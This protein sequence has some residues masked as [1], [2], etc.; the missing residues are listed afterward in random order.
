MLVF[1][2]IDSGGTEQRQIIIDEEVFHGIANGE[3]ETFCTLYQ[4]TRS[5]VFTYALS[6]LHNQSDAE[7]AM[8]DTYLKIRASAHLYRPEGKPMAWILTITRN[9]CL[10]KMRSHKHIAD[11]PVED[12]PP[13]LDFQ[14]IEDAEDRIVLKT[15]FRV[16][17]GEECQI[18]FLH[19]V[20]GMKHREIAD[21]LNMPL[22]TVLSK[23][24]RGLK[25]LKSELE[26]SL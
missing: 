12:A 6:L 13:V 8:H 3:K 14:Q 20:S 2:A 4:Q 11:F 24:R 25:K 17:S 23:Y 1:A 16:L 26:G 10:M 5:A 15:A 18:V 9:V 21:A 19:A 7:D 22:S